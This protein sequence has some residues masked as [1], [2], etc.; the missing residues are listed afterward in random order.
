MLVRAYAYLRLLGAQGLRDSALHA[1]LN[2]NYLRVCLRDSFKVPFDRTCMHEFV[3]EG[4]VENSPVRALD[5]S[6]R[7]IDYGFHPPTNYFPLIVRE[8]L[9]IEPTETESKPTL[10]AFVGA[11]RAIAGEACSNPELL[12]SAPH[13]TPTGRLDEVKAARQLILNDGCAAGARHA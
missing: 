13:V 11:M 7:L 3:C 10:D 5:I 2:A 6:K 8:A 4:R 12:L 9:M 1:V